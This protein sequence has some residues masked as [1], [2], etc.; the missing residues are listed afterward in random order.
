MTNKEK[1]LKL[2][3]YLED[4]KTYQHAISLIAFDLQTIAPKKAR[5]NQSETL[6]KLSNKIFEITKNEEYVKFLL[7]LH[8]NNKGLNTYQKRLIT[9]LYRRY[10]SSKNITAKMDYDYTMACYKSYDSWLKAKEANNYKIFEKDFKNIVD[11]CRLFISLRDDKK[12]IPYDTLLNDYEYGGSIA[13]LDEIF[14]KLKK[15]II[16]ILKDR[17]NVKEIDESFLTRKVAIKKQEKFSK[18]LMKTIG[19]DM[20]ATLLATTEHP[21]TSMIAKHD[22]RITT[23]YYERLFFSNVYS[24]IHEGGHA[25]YGQNESKLAYKYYLNDTMSSGMHECMSRF[26][27]NMVGRSKAFINFI[28]PTFHKQFKEFSDISKD[29]LYEGVNIAKPS[30]IRTEADE[31]TYCLHI[32]IRYEIEKMLINGQVEVEDLPEIWNQKYQEYLGIDCHDDST[33]ILQDV[34]WSDG[35]FGYFPSY[36]L[37]N[38]YAAQIMH[39]M[40]KEFDVYQ[41]IQEG[42]FNLI[43]KWLYKH[44][45]KYGSLMDPNEWIIKV[46]NEPINPKYYIE[47]LTN[48]YSLTINKTF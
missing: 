26:Y 14:S 19:L 32:I 3:T 24:T 45:F 16:K 27:E 35:S 18:Y 23:H 42:K 17:E 30:L 13:Q 7:D 22:V 21:F 11:Y 28:Y 5:E 31:L 37:G 2:I 48:K 47:Y 33:G 40:N 6:S 43:K 1:Y 44:A 20:N 15:A 9:I 10:I 12:N 38:I 29:R 4:I 41:A 8:E 46:T 36:A 39:Y 25:L 34:H